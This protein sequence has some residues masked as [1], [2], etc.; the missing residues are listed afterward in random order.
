MDIDEKMT[1]ALGAFERLVKFLEERLDK[2]Q[3]EN[4]SLRNDNDFLR[5]QIAALNASRSIV[6]EIRRDM[7]SYPRP[8]GPF[9]PGSEPMD[10]T[11]KPFDGIRTLPND[12]PFPDPATAQPVSVPNPVPWYDQ[13]KDYRLNSPDG[14][15]VGAGKV[16]CIAGCGN[17]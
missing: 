14:P 1:A 9:V 6:K 15:Y 8:I 7:P 5:G 17:A 13:G 16:T 11:A 12:F 2:L 10:R 3:K 4:D